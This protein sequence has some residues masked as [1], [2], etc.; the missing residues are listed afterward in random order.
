M[1]N[2]FLLN[3]R[4]LLDPGLHF[5][6]RNSVS[7]KA[8]SGESNHVTLDMTVSWNK[9]SVHKLLPKYSLEN[10]YNTDEFGLLFQCLPNQFF[11]LKSKKC[12]GGKIPRLES[13]VWE[14]LMLLVKNYQC[15]LLVK[16]R[17][18]GVLKTSRPHHVDVGRRKKAVFEE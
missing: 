10:I 3:T 12:S 1:K 15:L 2:I 11:K 8:K 16:Q 18:L 17:I 6:F 13:M 5:L 7:F 9:T 4:F 14:P